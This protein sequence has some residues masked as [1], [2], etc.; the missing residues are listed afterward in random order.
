MTES[1]AD[2]ADLERRGLLAS[3]AVAFFARRLLLGKL[4][5]LSG[6]VLRLQESYDGAPGEEKVFGS[7]RKVAN[8]AELVV[9]L[10]VRD[11][12]FYTKALSGG[13]VGAGE[14]YMAGYWDCDDLTGLVRLLVRHRAL[15]QS[16][17]GG[18]AKLSAPLNKAFHRLRRNNRRGSRRNI[19]AHYDLSNEFFELF[20]DRRMMY[21]C[22][23][24]EQADMDLDAASEAKLERICRK[25]D[26]SPKDHL[27]EI[28]TGWGGLAMHA[29]HRYGCRVTTTTIS[30]AQADYARRRVVEAGLE[31]RVEIMQQDYR[32]LR[33]QYNKLVSV[34]MIEAVG[35]DHLDTY[36]AACQGLLAPHGL[37]LLQVITIDDRYYDEAKRSV[38]FI[39]RYIFPGSGIPSLGAMLGSLKQVSHLTPIHLEDIGLHY[40]TTLQHWRQRFMSRLEEVRR[41]GFS[42]RFV[43]MWDFYLCYC[44]GGF[45]ERAISNAQILLAAPGYRQPAPLGRLSEPA[46]L[47]GGW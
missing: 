35:L 37:M 39:Q 20:L 7:R 18:W 28:G 24:Y 12:R 23:V 36:F 3:G 22:A 19:E 34:E 16:L 33:G 9:T 13:S 47:E 31:Q 21:S 45:R 25:L 5:Q 43:R 1:V 29:A 15:M 38:D 2:L 10:R 41:L 17:E 27:L 44:E 42:E 8:S 32:D 6:D 40:A 26:L 11:L 4:A 46:G 14:A 30:P